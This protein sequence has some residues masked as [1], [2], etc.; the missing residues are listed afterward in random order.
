[1][2]DDGVKSLYAF[3][4]G[5]RER[6]LLRNYRGGNVP[7][8]EPGVG[9]IVE[10]DACTMMMRYLDH[11]QVHITG[12]MTANL[13]QL[14]SGF[15]ASSHDLKMDTFE[16]S[17]SSVATELIARAALRSEE[18]EHVLS[19][20]PLPTP[21]ESAPVSPEMPKKARRMS[22]GKKTKAQQVEEEAKRMMA[23]EEAKRPKSI[24]F[25]TTVV[26]PSQIKPCGLSDRTLRCL[27]VRCPFPVAKD[28][29]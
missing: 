7:D 16:F 12:Q 22:Q 15:D 5:P 13:F 10:S 14:P 25:S 6:V 9:Y 8:T 1:M 28:E 29:G 26:P 21:S 11:T 24:K 3:M 4:Q 27:E 17:G 23:E 19:S 20:P 2:F 18:I